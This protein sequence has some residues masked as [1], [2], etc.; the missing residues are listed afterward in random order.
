M[1]DGKLTPEQQE[2][3]D[4]L[5]PRQLNFALGILNGMP[6]VEAYEKAGY[7]VKNYDTRANIAS[8]LRGNAKVVAFIESVQKSSTRKKM[9]TRDEAIEILTEFADDSENTKGIRMK[10]VSQLTRLQGWEAP[11]RTEITGAEGGPIRY[12]DVDAGK[13]KSLAKKLL[14]EL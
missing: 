8:R 5:S 11:Q 10:A 14:S 1:S 12:K 3:A 4:K 2:L 6:A 7:K 9:L 13:Y